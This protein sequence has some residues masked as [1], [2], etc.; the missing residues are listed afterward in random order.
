MDR[1]MK[2]DIM[3]TAKNC[4]TVD[5]MKDSNWCA[6]NK[7]DI[8]F[9][10]NKTLKELLAAKKISDRQAMSFHMEARAFLQATVKQLL[11]KSPLKYSLT[12]NLSAL[13]PRN[14]SDASKRDSNRT[15]FRGIVE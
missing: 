5:I 9:S 2:P 15:H 13:G 6:Y 3:S 10:A 8:G 14:V 4:H 11:L 7:I 1:F 12:K